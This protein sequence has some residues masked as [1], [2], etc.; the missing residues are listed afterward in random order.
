L[1]EAQVFTDEPDNTDFLSMTLGSE[2]SP[3]PPN[4]CFKL[5]CQKHR[6]TMMIQITRIFPHDFQI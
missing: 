3:N 1:S 6:F 2:K 4:P 5:Y